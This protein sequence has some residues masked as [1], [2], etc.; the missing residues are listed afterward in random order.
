[1]ALHYQLVDRRPQLLERYRTPET[2]DARAWERFLSASLAEKSD[3]IK[4]DAL[5]KEA[6]QVLT[7][8]RRKRI[9]L[10]S[11][12][13]GEVERLMNLFLYVGSEFRNISY[14]NPD[15]LRQVVEPE[16]IEVRKRALEASQNLFPVL[17]SQ[18][19]RHLGGPDGKNK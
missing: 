2:G 7:D 15:N 9:Y 18:F 14:R 12:T 8:F 1:M 5:S 6:S 10:S 19:R 11:G 3:N 16:V 13:A 4:A 17:E